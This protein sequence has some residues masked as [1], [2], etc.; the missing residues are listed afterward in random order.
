MLQEAKEECTTW[1]AQ[2]TSLISTLA[3]TRTQLPESIQQ[4]IE[5][6]REYLH[7]YKDNRKL[8]VIKNARAFNES[9]HSLSTVC[10]PVHHVISVTN[11]ISKEANGTLETKTGVEECI[12]ATSDQNDSLHIS[13]RSMRKMK[14]WDL[15]SNFTDSGINVTKSYGSPKKCVIKT[16]QGD[17]IHDHVIQRSCEPHQKYFTCSKSG[18]L[19]LDTSYVCGNKYFKTSEDNLYSISKAQGSPPEQKD[20]SENK[21]KKSAIIRLKPKSDCELY[22]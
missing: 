2:L 15:R 5:S 18:N 1:K 6:I 22:M 12:M 19:Y 8:L 13:P 17:V 21:A 11:N 10:K 3:K 14:N 20:I 9:I 7:Q 4:Q 16:L